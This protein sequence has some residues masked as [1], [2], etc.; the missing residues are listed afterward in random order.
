MSARARVCLRGPLRECSELGSRAGREAE[1]CSLT[2]G[3]QVLSGGPGSLAGQRAQGQQTH[4]LRRT[5]E[6][7]SGP[8]GTQSPSHEVPC[9]CPIPLPAHPGTQ[10][11]TAGP[12]SVTLPP[13][14]AHGAV[15]LMSASMTHWQRQAAERSPRG[16][17]RW[18]TGAWGG[19]AEVPGSRGRAFRVQ[20]CWGQVGGPSQ[21]FELSPALAV[22]GSE[23]GGR[24]GLVRGEGRSGSSQEAGQR[25]AGCH[26]AGGGWGACH[27]HPRLWRDT[28]AYLWG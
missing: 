23:L 20:Q 1:T 9:L 22:E 25:A 4:R 26:R 13:P 27:S 14:P 10:A 17:R 8:S 7:S 15:F 16:P 2:S 3:P 28:S 18:S 24:G 12:G 5:H 21:A 19:G 6:V 11:P